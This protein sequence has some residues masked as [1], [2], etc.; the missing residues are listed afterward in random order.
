MIFIYLPNINVNAIQSINI[1]I[2]PNTNVGVNET[3][4]PDIIVIP[5]ASASV[6]GS[7][8]HNLI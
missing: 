2:V 6:I 8:D 7:I 1:K 4:L 3:E 5:N